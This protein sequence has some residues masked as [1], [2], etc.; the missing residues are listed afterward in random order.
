MDCKARAGAG[1]AIADANVRD[2]V[3]DGDDGSR[4][5]VADRL[6][7]GKARL[8]CAQCC[9]ESV[10]LDLGDDIADEI[11][12]GFSLGGETLS[13]EFGRGTLRTRGNQSDCGSNQHASGQ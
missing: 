6:R 10:A 8:N 1:N 5:T 2:S 3:C 4:A 13:C 7:L 9:G 11:G 12:T